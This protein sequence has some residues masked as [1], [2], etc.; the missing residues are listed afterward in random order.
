MCWYIGYY[1]TAKT[2]PQY[3]QRANVPPAST[4]HEPTYTQ[5][6]LTNLSDAPS[7]PYIMSPI[8]LGAVFLEN[9]TSY[10]CDLFFIEKGVDF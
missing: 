6:P 4:T 3:H 5:L 9:S 7:S 10:F 8:R 2:H 1:F